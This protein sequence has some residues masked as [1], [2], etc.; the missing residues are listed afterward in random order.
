MKKNYFLAI[1]LILLVFI[2]GHLLQ[3]W[4][5][6]D[7]PKNTTSQ[8][9]TP[10]V[11]TAE[12][13]NAVPVTQSAVIV[14]DEVDE[15]ENAQPKT[16]QTFVIETDLVRAT[17]TNKGGDLI[18][19]KLKQ[20]TVAG[21]TEKVEMIKN[22]KDTNRTLGISLG[23]YNAPLLDNIFDVKEE[24]GENGEKMISFICDIGIKNTS[25]EVEK[26]KLSKHFRF[27]P[28]EYLF[29]LVVTIEGDENFSSLNFGNV[30]YTIRTAP[31]VGPD[32]DKTD[33]YDFRRFSLYTNGKKKDQ[34]LR[35]GETRAG[36]AGTT[37]VAVSGKYFTFVLIPDK[38]ISTLTLSADKAVDDKTENTQAFI[39]QP[40]MQTSS[41]QN[42]Y[43]IYLGP[44][45]EKDLH[46]YSNP[47]KNSFGIRDLGLDNLATGGGFLG[48]IIAVIKTL[49][50]ITYKFVKNWGVAI[51]IVTILIKL[52]MLPLSV[53]SIVGTQ[54]LQP[55]QDKISEINKKYKSN[56]QKMQEELSKIYAEAGYTPNCVGGCLPLILQF[57]V[58]IAM[59]QLFNNYFEFRGATFIPGWISDLSLGDSVYKFKKPLPVLNW[60]DLRLL[61]IIY[62]STQYLSTFISRQMPQS[63]EMQSTMFMMMYIMPAMFFFML[64]NAPSGLFV[65][66]IVSNI[67]MTFQQFITNRIIK[68]EREKPK[69]KK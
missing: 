54:K 63:K 39:S 8:A 18:S 11:S 5:Y 15:D 59:F 62:I 36:G 42:A 16:E 49:L 41:L 46:R 58:I 53:K 56:P 6:K 10:P 68:R 17:F 60:T 66:W 64:Y 24:T 13:E 32:W 37:W 9:E 21:S 57:A 44:R 19:Y 28:G 52:V 43:K 48:P 1:I 4:L 14:K 45:G 23:G 20:H 33:R 67:F 47:T 38:T 31:Q 40:A 65:Y 22:A 50:Q 29:E 30:S 69:T 26:I 7:V 61:P 2:G 12:S 55:Y 51:I 35:A 25:G 27:V 3:S 34:S